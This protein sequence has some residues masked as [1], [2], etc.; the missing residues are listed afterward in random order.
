MRTE[1]GGIPVFELKVPHPPREQVSMSPEAMRA[2]TKALAAA[3]EAIKAHERRVRDALTPVVMPTA[4]PT[5]DLGPAS[6]HLPPDAA[7]AVG[8]P[9]WYLAAAVELDKARVEILNRATKWEEAT[10]ATDGM[11]GAP[12]VAGLVSSL[13]VLRARA[14]QRAAT[15]HSSPFA[16]PLRAGPPPPPT[17]RDRRRQAESDAKRVM[18]KLRSGFFDLQD[19]KGAEKVLARAAKAA[20]AS[21][22]YAAAFLKK[23]GPKGLRKLLDEGMDPCLVSEVV[24]RASMAGVDIKLLKDALGKNRADK[25]RRAAHLAACNRPAGTFH[26]AW[27]EYL[28]TTLHEAP[29]TK[30]LDPADPRRWYRQAA[31]NVI[32]E[33]LARPPAGKE[34]DADDVLERI[35]AYA[36]RHELDPAGKRA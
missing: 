22:E 29:D 20:A 5:I 1:P 9:K 21:P 33:H 28:V 30:P 7:E 12:V 2:L 34:H 26:P 13:D 31:A 18:D 27:A 17:V 3:H 24:A 14:V 35:I 19:R 11:V 4:E 32:R 6:A 8:Q 10:R 25:P 16:S 23:L 36:A 15:G